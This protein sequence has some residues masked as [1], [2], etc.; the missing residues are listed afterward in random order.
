MFNWASVLHRQDINL[1]LMQGLI[2]TKVE[3]LL[4][5]DKQAKI[6]FFLE[7]RTYL[8]PHANLAAK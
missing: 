7:P 1:P 3:V 4:I 6:S 5:S 2:V 8:S